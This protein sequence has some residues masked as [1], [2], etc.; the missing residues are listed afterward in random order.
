VLRRRRLTPHDFFL[1]CDDGDGDGD[2]GVLTADELYGGLAFLG[3][4]MD[5][6]LLESIFA[7]IDADGDGKVSHAE[8]CCMLGVGIEEERRLLRDADVAPID[9]DDAIAGGRPQSPEWWVGFD[10]ALGVEAL[11]LHNPP[12]GDWREGLPAGMRG[13][14]AG[15]DA[16]GRA[17]LTAA[18]SRAAAA[19][20]R[21]SGKAQVLGVPPEVP[22]PEACREIKVQLEP[23]KR[24]TCV[25]T[26]RGV[27]SR[28]RIS[29]WATKPGSDLFADAHARRLS[30]GHYAHGGSYKEPRNV[31]GVEVTEG[32]GGLWAA[33]QRKHR[34]LEAALAWQTPHPAAYRLVWS[35][36]LGDQPLFAW[37]A[38]PPSDA[39]VCLGMLFTTTSEPPALGAMRC[40][41][42]EWTR[43]AF[44][45]PRE[46]WNDRG[47]GGRA[48]SLWEVNN[49][50]HCWAVAGYHAPTRIFHELREWPFCLTLPEEPPDLASSASPAPATP[51]PTSPASAVA[52]ANQDA[53][54]PPTASTAAAAPPTAAIA[55]A[56]IAAATIASTSLDSATI[57]AAF[58]AATATITADALTAALSIVDEAEVE[59]PAE[60]TI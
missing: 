9:P 24:L 54:A 49:M 20:S 7:Q 45:Q 11:P 15:A 25:W 56:T 14:P 59:G 55:T 58:D 8:W 60:Y 10:R 16:A 31:L 17:S 36:T 39:F 32:E 6:S 30:T 29:V 23:A 3:V 1:R 37:E 43:Q 51:A 52:P 27:Y 18:P 35:K 4:R 42:R 44:E 53:V 22:P 48:G 57:A 2:G 21:R 38:E 12:A 5:V 41:H 46:L 33:L 19:P 26:S 13:S 34:W 50:G 47:T 40:V 28:D